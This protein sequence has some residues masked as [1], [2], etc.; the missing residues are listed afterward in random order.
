[1]ASQ[2]PEERQRKQKAQK[3]IIDEEFQSLLPKLDEETYRLLEEN[4][5]QN[6]CRDALV[7][8]NDI[9]IDGHHR[10]RIALEHKIPFETVQKDFASRAE[11]LIW[12]VSS[13]I[14]RRNLTPIQLSHFRGL[15]YRAEKQIQGTG[16]KDEQMYESGQNDHFNSST[17]TRLSTKYRV[18]PRTIRRDAN[19]SEGIDAI[20][21]SSPEAKKLILAGEAAINKKELQGLSALPQKEI[22]KIALMI[23]R[24][25]YESI[26]I[27]TA[28]TAE[29]LAVANDT[30]AAPSSQDY[31]EATQTLGIYIR[32]LTDEFVGEI[33]KQL[34]N[35]NKE[36]QRQALRSYIDRLEEV[37]I[38][39]G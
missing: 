39:I 3:I 36:K 30:G 38:Q 13:L 27:I 35:D 7:L 16:R 34:N 18:S 19:L 31:Q 4:I 5:I 23:E 22:K 12:I 17:A 14:S 6:G 32:R 8:W 11:C 28:A 21:S 9:L 33:Q 26:S 37:Y 20:G 1:M 29:G 2:K 15:H 25:T 24:G 10:Y